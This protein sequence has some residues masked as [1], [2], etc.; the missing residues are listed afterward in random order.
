MTK[1]KKFVLFDESTEEFIPADPIS[2]SMPADIAGLYHAIRGNE[3]TPTGKLVPDLD[4]LKKSAE[5]VLDTGNQTTT[6]IK[7]ARTYSIVIPIDCKI[8]GK[9]ILIGKSGAL[10][11]VANTG[12]SSR[13][14][15]NVQKNGA[16]ISGVTKT[17]GSSHVP[18]ST[19]EINYTEILEITIPST[20]FSGGDSFDV[21]VE[22]EVVSVDATNPGIT[23]KLYCDPATSGNELVLYLQVT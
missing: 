10:N 5:T 14:N 15:L 7:I 4:L 22:L 20:D 18:N 6:G 23:T 17:N 12:D 19:T 21:V 11:A 9:V 16:A 1:P 13:I 2:A 8:A 3:A